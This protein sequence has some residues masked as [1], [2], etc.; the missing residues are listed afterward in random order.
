M[1]VR[2]GKGREA[3]AEG[4]SGRKDRIARNFDKLEINEQSTTAEDNFADKVEPDVIAEDQESNE[5]VTQVG[6]HLGRRPRIALR[7]YKLICA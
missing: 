3:R 1:H 4:R 2:E 7:S 6:E 5:V